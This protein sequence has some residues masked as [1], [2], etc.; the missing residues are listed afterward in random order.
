MTKNEFLTRLREGL[1]GLPR[2]DAAERLGFYSEMIDD[3]VE[4]GLTEAEAVAEIGPPDRIAAQII[5]DTPITR[6]VR[7]KVRPK[8]RLRAWEVVFL[9]LGA[10]I[11]LSLLI[12]AFAVV[13]SLY[14]VLWALLISLWAVEISLIV[15]ALGGVAAGVWMF[16]RGDRA[17]GL[18]LLGAGLILAGLSVFLFFGCVAAS[19]GTVGLTKKIALWIKSLFLRKETER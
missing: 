1:A 8:R 2:E 10:P 12:A 11:W 19:R 6:L 18:A 15:G 5:R 17:Q 16:S 14:V 3:R 4:D 7:E 13:F 9:V